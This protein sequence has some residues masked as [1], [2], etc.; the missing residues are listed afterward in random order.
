MSSPPIPRSEPAPEPASAEVEAFSRVAL[1]VAHPDGP[2]LFPNLMHELA[3]SLRVRA[4]YMAAFPGDSRCTMRTLAIS[5][6][7]RS[8]P[9]VGFTVDGVLAAAMARRAFQSIPG[10]LLPH[11]DACGVLAGEPLQAVS[12]LTLTD[13]AGEPLGLLVA[14]DGRPIARTDAPRTEAL[15]R[16]VAIRAAAQ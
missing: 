2:E 12:A 8:R 6:D 11:L 1:A 7:G 4:V 14:M 9:N 5:L 10:S 3:A 13:T 15:L 16:L